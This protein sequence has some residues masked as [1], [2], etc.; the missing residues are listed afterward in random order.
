MAADVTIFDPD[1]VKDRATFSDPNQYPVGINFVIVNGIIVLAHGEHTM[2]K[3]GR[4]LYGRG[5]N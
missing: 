4:V 2:A 5:K 3:P 1:K